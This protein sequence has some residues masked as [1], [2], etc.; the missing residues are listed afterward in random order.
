MQREGEMEDGVW[1]RPRSPFSFWFLALTL[2]FWLREV[3]EDPQH[4]SNTLSFLFNTNPVFAIQRAF[5]KIGL[6]S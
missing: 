4:L 6:A 3:P 2:H 1:T 5:P